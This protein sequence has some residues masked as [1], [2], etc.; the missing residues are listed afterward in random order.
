MSD[1]GT[2]LL[3]EDDPDIADML[4]LVFEREG[5]RLTHAASGEDGLERL[6]TRAPRAVLLDLGLPGIDGIEAGRRIRA[7]WGIPVIM[8]TGRDNEIE[9]IGGVEVG[10]DD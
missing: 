4:T 6:E 8:L 1:Q 10:A 5:F 7:K 9:Q 2:V 3:I